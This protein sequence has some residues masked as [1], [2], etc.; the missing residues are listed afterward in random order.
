VSITSAT[1][2]T[3]STSGALICA[4]GAGISGNIN[5]GGNIVAGGFV[6]ISSPTASFNSTS[7]ALKC[8]GGAGIGGN[9]YSGGD[10]VSG[11]SMTIQNTGGSATALTCTGSASISVNATVGGILR[12]NSTSAASDTTSGAL[13][14]AGGAGIVGDLYVGGNGVFTGTV[15][16]SSDVR[17]KKNVTPLSE[18][19]VKA[20]YETEV[21]TYNW[22][23]GDTHEQVGVIAQ[24]LVKR[25]LTNLV[26][27]HDN[28]DMDEGEDTIL[29][30]SKK[31]WSVSYS[32]ITAYNMK[33][34]QILIAENEA[35][36]QRLDVLE[37][38]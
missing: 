5:S 7:G 33:M 26:Y 31:Q 12:T 20:L 2:S 6:S 10:I 15:T 8:I 28:K 34:I 16:Q 4:G 25:G 29:N 1:N 19:N 36:K 27:S 14:V 37:Q 23:Q 35:L 22:K 30:P 38:K 18:T 9:I 32:G 21:V 24:E 11:G 13:R 3:N 17:L